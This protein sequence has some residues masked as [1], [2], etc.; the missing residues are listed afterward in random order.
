YIGRIYERSHDELKALSY[1]QRALQLSSVG[2]DR[3][4]ESLMLSN[5]AHLE[6]DSG[7]LDRARAHI[8]SA[9]EI[10]ESLRAK[11]GSQDLRAT[12]FAS[13]RQYYDLYI[14]ILMRLHEQRPDAK[15]DISAFEASEK[16]RA[17]SLLESLRE[18]HTD[19]RQGADPALLKQERELK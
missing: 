17:R 16:A 12:Y 19:I 3:V 18:A 5:L 9:I 1:Y 14:D 7:N 11:L 10:A 6:R 15:F 13:A 2:A 4:G 8:E